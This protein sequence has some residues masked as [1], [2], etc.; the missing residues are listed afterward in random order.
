MVYSTFIGVISVVFL[1]T[2]L[3]LGLPISVN[4]L[5]VTMVGVTLV[6]SFKI[7][8][9]LLGTGMYYTVANSTFLALPLFIFMGA[10]AAEGGFAKLAY[11]GINK[12]AAGIP[13]SLGIATCYGCAAF[14]ALSGS[15]LAT[16]A[17]FGKMVLPEMTEY[18][19]N[20][21]FSVGCIASA[22]TFAVM[23]PPSSL[24]IV[25]ALFTNTSVARLFAAGVIPGLITATVYSIS[26][27]YR[28]KNKPELAPIIK[29]PADVSILDRLMGIINMW[30]ILLIASI[31]FGGIY[32]GLF[33]PIE[34]AAVG[35]VLVLVFGWL[36][37][38]IRSMSTIKKCLRES[39]GTCSMIFLIMISALL[40]SRFL[41]ITQIPNKLSLF[42]LNLDLPRLYF[43]IGILIVWFFMGMLVT[44]AAIYALT[45]PIVFP[46]ITNL[47]YDPIWF[48]VI[49]LKL[50]EIA[51]V[52]PPV[53]LNIFSLK[54][55]AGKDV[56]IE[57]I[58][59]GVWPF[60]LCDIIVLVFLI[61]FPQLTLW[62]PNLLLH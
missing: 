7:A 48:G 18:G 36:Q 57:D 43:L 11:K 49:T 15:S 40:F 62:L 21:T 41:A 52:T 17:I 16:T 14:G 34:A 2:F 28:V 61:A 30:P 54:A 55:V 20:K 35:C 38:K 32:T 8:I 37:K 3:I 50:S 26:I 29:S 45:L 58:Y 5:L 19:Y 56:P 59:R 46:I 23:I 33:T 10:L 12:L 53:G 31:I 47:G 44:P 6:T 51:A 42:I 9:S 22:G 25:F 60:V 27:L 4:F 13:G 24:F 39:A 1:M